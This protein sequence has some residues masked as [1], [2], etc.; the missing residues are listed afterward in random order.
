MEEKRIV[1]KEKRKK[2]LRV[3]IQKNNLP[4]KVKSDPQALPP[5]NVSGVGGYVVYPCD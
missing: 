3:Y 1:D 4:T 5:R 2:I